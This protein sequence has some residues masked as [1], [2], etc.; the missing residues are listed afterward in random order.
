MFSYIVLERLLPT[1]EAVKVPVGANLIFDTVVSGTGTA[2]TYD[3]NTGGI[4]FVDAGFYYVD[5]YVA[6]QSGL[7]TDGNN[8]AI[9]TAIGEQ[10]F[11]GS[12]HIKISSPTGFA[13]IEAGAGE[14]AQ[15]VN[16]SDDSLVLSK[17][18]KSKA[19]LCVY[20]LHQ[21]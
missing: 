9:L 15:L 8:W 3:G 18:V 2:I 21:S 7:S 14:T 4:T 11:V 16:I 6:T 10:S 17:V 12:S 13:L 1:D 5:W 20:G 19:G